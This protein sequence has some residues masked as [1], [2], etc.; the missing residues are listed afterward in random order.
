MGTMVIQDIIAIV[1]MVDDKIIQIF[2]MTLIVKRKIN[3]SHYGSSGLQDCR[4]I[5]GNVP[6]KSFKICSKLNRDQCNSP[7]THPHTKLNK[8]SEQIR[9]NVNTSKVSIWLKELF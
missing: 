4:V 7:F 5:M 6:S 8:N 9:L 3:F 2:K 1:F